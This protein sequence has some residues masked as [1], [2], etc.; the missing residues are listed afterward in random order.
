MKAQTLTL[1]G[2]SEISGFWGPGR[3]TLRGGIR[4]ITGQEEDELWEKPHPLEVDHQLP[5]RL[6]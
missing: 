6:K 2:K 1:T 3:L 5:P 4:G